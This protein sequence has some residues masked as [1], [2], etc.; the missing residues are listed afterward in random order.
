MGVS[1]GLD[2]SEARVG[3]DDVNLGF[4]AQERTTRY[5]RLDPF[6]PLEVP[7]ELPLECPLVW[8]LP[9]VAGSGSQLGH[10]VDVR[11]AGDSAVGEGYEGG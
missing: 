11:V 2:G 8:P 5:S 1:R 6:W 10:I 3:C 4:R 9:L 7:L